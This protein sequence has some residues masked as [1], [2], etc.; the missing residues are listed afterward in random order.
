[1]RDILVDLSERANMIEQEIEHENSRFEQLIRRL[2]SE[3]DRRIEDLKNQLQA[4]RRL[5]EI[6]SWQY[7]VR[8]A[9]LLSSTVAGAIERSVASTVREFC[10]NLSGN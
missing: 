7:N 9:L 3:Q 1:M 8:A 6:A 5:A 2:K 4:V 10:P